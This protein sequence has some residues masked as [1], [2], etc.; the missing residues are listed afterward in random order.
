MFQK[1]VPE[2]QTQ[3]I[4]RR[5]KFTNITFT[6]CSKQYSRTVSFM[7]CL[8]KLNITFITPTENTDV[9][10]FKQRNRTVQNYHKSLENL[11]D[12]FWKSVERASSPLGRSTSKF[13]DLYVD[14][15][16]SIVDDSIDLWLPY[17][18]LKITEQELCIFWFEEYFHKILL[19]S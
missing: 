16:W 14:V 13:R 9:K 18:V 11:S 17:Y 10:D 8:Q 2:Q 5:A 15:R 7:T 3:F 4:A 6:N 12:Q 1:T 19:D